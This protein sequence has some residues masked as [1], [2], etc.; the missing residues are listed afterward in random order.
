MRIKRP[1]LAMMFAAGSPV[2]ITF[3]SPGATPRPYKET[4]VAIAPGS[5]QLAMKI[6]DRGNR[7]RRLG[8][9][10]AANLRRGFAPENLLREEAQFAREK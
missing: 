1:I 9:A 2:T 10:R 4:V 6:H 7:V 5:A 8:F 3:D